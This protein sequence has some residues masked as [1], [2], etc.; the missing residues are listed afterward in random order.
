MLDFYRGLQGPQERE[1]NQSLYLGRADWHMNQSNQLSSTVNI[2]RWDSPN[3][4]QTAPTHANHFTANGS[5]IVENETVIGRW[6]SIISRSLVSELRFQWGRDFE[7][8]EPNAAGPSVGVTNGIFFGMPNFLPRAAYP[9]ERRYQVS[10]N[11][12]WL[13]GQ[14]SVSFGYDM[15][16]LRDKVI[17][18]FSGGGVYSY[19]SANNLALDCPNITLPLGACTPTPGTNAG[20]NYTSFAQQFDSL[21]QAGATD[22][23][24]K[25]FALFVEDS[26]KARNNLT[27]NF[28]LRYELQTMPTPNRKPRRSGDAADQYGQE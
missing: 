3:G 14:H 21:G 15:N 2:L 13:R 6:S 20:R 27:L 4:I 16:W 12:S 8:Q 19:P 24:N 25:D 9:N 18:L 28:G 26:W 22:F 1:G 23:S 10:Q 5:D 17:N 7:A 11:F